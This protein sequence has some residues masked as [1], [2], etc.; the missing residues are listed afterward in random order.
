[1]TTT[2]ISDR[3]QEDWPVKPGHCLNPFEPLFGSD[4]PESELADRSTIWPS[5]SR[6]LTD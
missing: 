3:I 4:I 2:I 6:K 5:A 1:M